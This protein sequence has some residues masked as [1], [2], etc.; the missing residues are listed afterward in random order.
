MTFR[1]R[2]IG[3]VAGLA[4]LALGAA[5]CPDKSQDYD[6][7]KEDVA[8]HEDIST[9]KPRGV[10]QVPLVDEEDSRYTPEL[11]AFEDGLL[12]RMQD[13]RFRGQYGKAL[14][15]DASTSAISNYF[16]CPVTFPNRPTTYIG[17]DTQIELTEKAGAIEGRFSQA[18]VPVSL[19][20]CTR[21][22][23]AEFYSE[24]GWNPHIKEFIGP[25]DVFQKID[26]VAYLESESKALQGN[27][28]HPPQ[29]VHQ[30]AE[31]YY[32]P[33]KGGVV[34]WRD[35]LQPGSN[36][37]Q[38]ATNLLIFLN[39]ETYSKRSRMVALHTFLTTREDIRE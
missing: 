28:P 19:E 35:S 14:E 12:E 13:P 4:A 37:H 27:E 16:L 17:V 38:E 2:T 34:A 1:A 24:D 6:S 26:V 33:V 5:M 29:L 8:T 31:I 3:I 36:A 18:T 9:P 25:L 20:E 21:N 23:M 22:P 15:I 10:E 7:W 32:D 30:L 39:D 11:A